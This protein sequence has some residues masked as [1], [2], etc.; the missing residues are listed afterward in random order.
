MRGAVWTALLTVS[1]V[2]TRH[3]CYSTADAFITAMVQLV[4]R[5]RPAKHKPSLNAADVPPHDATSKD[6]EGMPQCSVDVA[7]GSAGLPA[8]SGSEEASYM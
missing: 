3:A 2:K 5:Y 1:A 6:A 4:G 8:T 7:P